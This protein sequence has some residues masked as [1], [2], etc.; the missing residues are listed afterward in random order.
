[1]R[2]FDHGHCTKYPPLVVDGEWTCDA[3]KASSKAGERPL[4][5]PPTTPIRTATRQALAA[6]REYNKT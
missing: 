6:L 5:Q 4:R 3:W 2:H 1:M